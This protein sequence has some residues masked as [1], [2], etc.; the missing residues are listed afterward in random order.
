MASQK[1]SRFNFLHGGS[2]KK[3]KGGDTLDEGLDQ[4]SGASGTVGPSTTQARASTSKQSTIERKGGLL[5]GLF[6]RTKTPSMPPI[7]AIPTTEQQ[8]FRDEMTDTPSAEKL[9]SKQAK[10]FP[11]AATTTNNRKVRFLELG[12]GAVDLLSEVSDAAGLVL[13][14]PVGAVLGK[15]TAILGTLKVCTTT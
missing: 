4:A 3:E 7:A 10:P 6:S 15:V 5:E 2:R 1:H 12:I 14:N 8:H 11:E 13:P 9:T